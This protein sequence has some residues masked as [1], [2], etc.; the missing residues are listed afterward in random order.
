[1]NYTCECYCIPEK[2]EFCIGMK[3]KYSYIID[4]IIVYQSE[5]RGFSFDEISF[6]WYFKKCDNDILQQK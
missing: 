5:N 1:M 2:T 6:L 4:G 3:Y